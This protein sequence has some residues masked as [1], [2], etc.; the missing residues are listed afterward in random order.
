ML[1]RCESIV[2]FSAMM[3]PVI[4]DAAVYWT[5]PH[6]GNA[7]ASNL[8]FTSVGEWAG[9]PLPHGWLVG[10][11]W[12][13]AYHALTTFIASAGPTNQISSRT[14]LSFIR[15]WSI[16]VI[17]VQELGIFLGRAVAS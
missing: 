9:L 6:Q 16:A 13:L 5:C 10:P 2:F 12:V 7:D 4:V 3:L 11:F 1:R 14:W 17:L 8:S 15:L